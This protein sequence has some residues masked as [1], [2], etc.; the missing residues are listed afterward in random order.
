MAGLGDSI[1]PGSMET[2]VQVRR[3]VTV[4]EWMRMHLDAGN[5]HMEINVRIR[6]TGDAVYAGPPSDGGAAIDG[7]DVQRNAGVLDAAKPALGPVRVAPVPRARAGS[8]S[9]WR[10][11]SV[12]LVFRFA[13]G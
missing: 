5:R 4:D 8:A 10:R 1:T 9:R 11:G 2:P 6:N 3:S 7:D 12:P 13:A